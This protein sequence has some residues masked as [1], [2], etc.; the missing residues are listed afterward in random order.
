[1]TVK[2]KRFS[3]STDL[4]PIGSST[5][6]SLTSLT[7]IVIVSESLKLGEPSSVAVNVTW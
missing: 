6:A 3:S 4:S 7:V 5:G 2:A 1:M